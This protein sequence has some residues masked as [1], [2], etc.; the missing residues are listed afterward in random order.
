MMSIHQVNHRHFKPIETE[1]K[2]I[3]YRSKLEARW[4]VYMEYLNID[5]LYEPEG[6]EMSDG[7]R[8]LPDFYFPKYG[9]YGE[10]KPEAEISDYD[11]R[12]MKEFGTQK[13]LFLMY[14]MPEARPTMVFAPW[15]INCFVVPFAFIQ[16][17]SY[18]F[19]WYSGYG[20]CD[21][22]ES[23]CDDILF[24]RA[25]YLARNEKFDLKW[26]RN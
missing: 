4:A 3:V 9:V 7:L 19:F 15:N 25:A 26:K 13:E 8:Y 18:G 24:K 1:F 17:E 2:G 6:F 20:F 16:K 14:G 22:N 10:V 11:M 5:F 23:F 12:K 21:K